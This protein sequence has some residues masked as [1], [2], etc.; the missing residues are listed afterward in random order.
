MKLKM[1]Q[2]PHL[3]E[4][5]APNR[6]YISII[7]HNTLLKDEKAPTESIALFLFQLYLEK[8][9]YDNVYK[10][11]DI[12]KNPQKYNRHFELFFIIERDNFIE[13]I[14]QELNALPPQSSPLRITIIFID[15]L[16]QL[17]NNTWQ[18]IE[19]SLVHLLRNGK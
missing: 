12:I 19:N 14:L 10:G 5:E 7:A 18:D 15:N 4:G 16:K 9:D 2:I 13:E 1:I 3:K 6:N 8:G 17:V 11:K